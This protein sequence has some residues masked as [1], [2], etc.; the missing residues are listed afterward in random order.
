VPDLAVGTLLHERYRAIRSLGKGGMGAVYEAV[1]TR[2]HN[3]VAVKLMTLTGAEA[4]RA[5]EREATLLAALRH[6]ALPVVIDYFVEDERQFLVMQYIEGEDLAHALQRMGG[7]FAA[8]E[9]LRCA[10]ALAGALAYL[11]R[12]DPP[13]VHRDLKPAN[14]NR[15]PAGEYVLLDFGLAKGRQPDMTVPADER[16]VYG[17]TPTYA[18]PEQIQGLATD[19]RSDIFAFGATLFHLAAAAPPPTAVE[20]LNRIAGGGPDPLAYRLLAIR[21]LDVRMQGVIA[22]ALALEPGNRFQSVVDIIDALGG[23]SARRPSPLPA[24]EIAPD[25]RRVDA[26]LPS[27][28]EVGR[29]IDLVVQVRFVDSPSLGIEDWPSRRRPDRIE[30][31]SE[32]LDVSYP[33]DPATGSRMPA[34]LRIRVVAPDFTLAGAAEQ[35]VDVPPREYSK[36]LAF[37]LTPVR[38][39]MCRVNVEVYA[40]DAVF[41]GV[42]AVE[43]EALYAAIAEST[44]RVAT[45]DLH[46]GAQRAVSADEKTSMM[47]SDAAAR[48]REAAEGAA[49]EQTAR[50]DAATFAKFGSSSEERAA[51]ERK[52][53]V[54]PRMPAAER[55]PMAAP[56]AIRP[57][58]ASSAPAS[59]TPSSSSSM[60]KWIAVVSAAIVLIAAGVTMLAP[61]LGDS[62]MSPAT[63]AQHAPSAASTTVRP[64]PLPDAAATPPPTGGTDVPGGPPKPVEAVPPPAPTATQPRPPT[65][66]SKAPAQPAPATEAAPAISPRLP[67]TMSGAFRAVVNNVPPVTF[68]D[69]TGC[70]FTLTLQDIEATIDVRRGTVTNGHLTAR[71]VRRPQTPCSQAEAKSELSYAFRLS[72]ASALSGTLLFAA[73]KSNDLN[74]REVQFFRRT[75]DDNAIRGSFLWVRGAESPNWTVQVEGVFRRR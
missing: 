29:P 60:R 47:S 31:A 37:L 35:L 45:I 56:A 51:A 62:Q 23:E 73:D 70:E 49:R 44:L 67:A 2:L 32:A 25:K 41:L 52:L 36:R 26:A 9:L 68:D 8:G 6:P 10:L 24:P 74:S 21:G 7:P 19:P 1:D 75:V 65:S 30:Q 63:T 66:S 15:T 16:S 54:A 59:S 50:L 4:N 38:D 46:V 5:F 28:A 20:R 71:A 53:P 34:R 58:P 61:R 69:G 27:R 14:V 3:T 13:I 12:R 43:A 57:Q 48:E 40:T 39:G 22:R 18:P 42:I 11:H 72:R 17:F 64:Q 55:A 33:T